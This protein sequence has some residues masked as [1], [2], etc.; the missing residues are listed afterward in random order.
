MKVSLTL[1]ERYTDTTHVQR[2]Y[3][4][5]NVEVT[6]MGLIESAHVQQIRRFYM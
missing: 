3:I 6:T 1:G 4:A 5:V 2:W